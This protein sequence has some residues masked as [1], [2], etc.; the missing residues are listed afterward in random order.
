MSLYVESN[1]TFDFTSA[2]AVIEHDRTVSA[3]P[4]GRVHGNSIWP[5]VDLC[6]EQ[7]SGEWIWLE[8]KNWDPRHIAPSRRGGSRWSFICKMRSNQFLKEMRVK[9]LGTMAYLAWTGSLPTAPVQFV[10]LFEPPKLLDSA[11]VGS[12][13]TRLRELIR[14]LAR[15]AHPIRVSVLT[16]VEWNARFGHIYP[17]S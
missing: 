1:I 10:L 4:G 3:V 17:A 11:L 7:P 2:A 14:N 5:G 15:W 13:M 12:R 9:F 6:I 16:L 8:V